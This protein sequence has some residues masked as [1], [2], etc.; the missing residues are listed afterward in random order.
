[1]IAAPAASPKPPR[2]TKKKP[3]AHQTAKVQVY[4]RHV[5]VGCGAPTDQH[6]PI[7]LPV[8]RLNCRNWS[9]ALRFFF[10]SHFFSLSLSSPRAKRWWEFSFPPPLPPPLPDFG[11]A[12]ASATFSLWEKHHSTFFLQ[13]AFKPRFSGGLSR[14]FDVTVVVCVCA[15]PPKKKPPKTL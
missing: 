3:G 9:W 2:T 15:R 4:R 13:A 10:S 5:R 7:R 8:C 14:G 11:Q 1:M 12:L 6:A